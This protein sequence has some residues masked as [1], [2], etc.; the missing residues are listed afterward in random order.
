[1]AP[2]GYR[3]RLQDELARKTRASAGMR[4]VELDEH[5]LAAA[6]RTS[7]SFL[8]ISDVAE[9]IADELKNQR[10]EILK[11][12]NRMFQHAAMKSSTAHYDLRLRNLHK[13]LVQVESEM[14]RL[15]RSR[16]P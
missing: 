3:S 2:P 16:S 9:A 5:A 11:H 7:A 6:A 10:R 1:M 4:Q 14:R 15:T 13:R 8:S 12:V